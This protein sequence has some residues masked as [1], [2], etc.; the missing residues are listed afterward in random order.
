MNVANKLKVSPLLVLVALV[1]LMSQKKVDSIPSFARQTDL[2]CNTCHYVFPELNPFGRQFK[3][4]GYTFTNSQSIEFTGSKDAANVRISRTMPLSAMVQ[5]S[6]VNVAKT[7]PGTQNNNMEFPQQLSFFIAGEITPRFGTFIQLTYEDQ[8]GEFG[9]DNTDIRFASQTTIGQKNLTYGITLNNSPTVQDVWNST[10]AWG[11][12]YES[13]EIAPAPG[14]ATMI[15]GAMAQEVVGLGAYGFY[16]DFLYGEVTGYRST[17]QGGPVPPDTLS[18]N[19]IK[20][21]TPYWR[22][23]IQHRFS[24]W[25]LEV[26]T[27]GMYTKQYPVG[28]SGFT[29]N[30]TDLALDFQL[31]RGLGNGTFIGH[32]TWIHEKQNLNATHFAGNSQNPSN[33]LNTVRLDAGY[34]FLAN[35]VVTLAFFST[36]GD[37]DTLLYAPGPL[38]GSRTGKPTSNGMIAEIDYL[39]WQN[40]KFT[41]QYTLYGKFNG[42][43]D[44]YDGYGRSA[45]DNNSLYIAGWVVF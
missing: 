43:G 19:T 25:Y 4:N 32:G 38:N 26:G 21:V 14:A 7:L 13:S 34:N 22:A 2:T 3:L 12:P 44:N 40:T 1:I 28:V 23:A 18:T 45:G 17:P 20:G 33:N 11:F 16:N 31:E 6:Y 37:R 5:A 30:Y 9:W 36:G 41:M 29:D 8:G 42:A 24:D 15:E 35:Y 10:P 27:Y 39:P